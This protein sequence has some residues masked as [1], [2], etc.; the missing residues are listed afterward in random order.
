MPNIVNRWL[1]LFLVVAVVLGLVAWY[2]P[3]PLGDPA[4]PTDSTYVPK[5]EWWVLFLNQLVGIFTG[6]LAVVGT[7][8]IPG[9]LVGLIMALP[10]IDRSPE[11]HPARRKKGDAY[12][13][14]NCRLVLL[15][16]IRDGLCR[17]SPNA[18]RVDEYPSFFPPLVF[19]KN[20]TLSL[21]KSIKIA[22]RKPLPTDIVFTAHPV[23][24]AF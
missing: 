21:S 7:V 3:A 15:S 19:K 14:G 8:I 1:V 24:A 13:S 4:D 17:A 9:G 16:S 2:W 11:L 5:P 6:P 18:P 23:G 20:L 10:F 12:R 22:A